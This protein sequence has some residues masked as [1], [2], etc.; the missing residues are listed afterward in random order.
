MASHLRGRLD[1]FARV[2]SAVARNP[3]AGVDLRALLDD[4]L[5]VHAT[6]EGEQ[7]VVDGPDVALRPKAAE[8][9]SLALHELTTNA[10][11][12][13]A[14]TLS[15][16]RIAVRWQTDGDGSPLQFQWIESGFDRQLG[17]PTRQGFGMELLTQ[18]LPY[19]LDAKTQVR[20]DDGGLSFSME[21][22][23][24]NILKA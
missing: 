2:Q 14:L 13:G 3:D 5:L 19:D 7:L 17:T 6:R 9:I 24:D 23:A 10:V 22:P 12:H 8:S 4:E 18:I 11:K 16:G 21:L 1:A 20:F 15:G